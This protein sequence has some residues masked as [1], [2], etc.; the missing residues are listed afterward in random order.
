MSSQP[1]PQPQ[2]IDKSAPAKL[3][4]GPTKTR[5]EPQAKREGPTL[6]Q[7]REHPRVKAFIRAANE[8]LGPKRQVVVG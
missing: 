5:T 3:Q 8:Q 1:A 7:V 6:D 4:R 2:P